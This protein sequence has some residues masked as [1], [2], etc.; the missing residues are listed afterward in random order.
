MMDT[1]VNVL[2]TTCKNIKDYSNREHVIRHF[3]E[4]LAGIGDEPWGWVMDCKYL[5]GK[6][7]VQIS[8]FISILKLL[9]KKY[10]K[11]KR[12]IYVMNGGPVM[13]TAMSAFKPF[14]DKAFYNSIVKLYGTPLELFEEFKK[15]GWTAAEV[16]PIIRKIQKD[17]V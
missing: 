14:M 2:Y 8:L 16:E 4:T 9:T 12:F 10:S 11:N 17:Y 13:N 3:E 1:R 7:M 6:H 15:L 5:T